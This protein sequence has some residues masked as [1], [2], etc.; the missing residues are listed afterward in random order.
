M[1]FLGSGLL[2]DFYN[3]GG[4]IASDNT[5]IDN[6]DPLALNYIFKNVEPCVKQTL[7][8]IIS[9]SLRSSADI[10]IFYER[11]SVV[12]SRS[13]G[14]SLSRV[15]S[16]IGNAA[17]YISLNGILPVEKLARLFTREINMN[18]VNN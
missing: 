13:R 18:A 14:V 12:D 9:D 1:H 4:G 16:R 17:D 3:V 5:V 11:R 6:D 15:E 8:F 10:F 2:E 7:F